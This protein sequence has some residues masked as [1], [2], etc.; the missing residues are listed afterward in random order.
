M[1]KSF[2]SSQ[3]DGSKTRCVRTVFQAVRSGGRTL[4]QIMPVWRPSHLFPHNAI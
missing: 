4:H 2:P 1:T 3:I